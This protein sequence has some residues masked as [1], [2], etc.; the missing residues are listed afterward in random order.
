MQFSRPSLH[1]PVI[2]APEHLALAR[3]QMAS[4]PRPPA[5]AAAAAADTLT[6]PLTTVSLNSNFDA[7]VDVWFPG[8]DPS[9]I[10]QLVVDSGNSVL[11]MPRWE[12]ITAVPNH[13]SSYTVLA[14]GHEPWGCPANIVRGP[15]CIPTTTG[16]P[17]VI[18]CVFFA[19][20]GDG[21]EGGRTAN[22]GTGCI[23]PWSANGWA[24]P[25]GAALTL[26]A[27][28]SYNA[29]YP[30]AVFDYAPAAT[31]QGAAGVVKVS[32]G[33]SLILGK[34]QPAGFTAFDIL[35][36]LEWM[37]VRPL[38]LAIGD[39]NTPWPGDIDSPIAVIDTGGGPVFLSDPHG[40][41]YRGAW[42]D[43]VDNPAWAS[44]SDSCE[45]VGAKI[46]VTIGTAAAKFSYIID[47][48]QFPR[49]AQGLTLVMCKK[50][51]YMMDQQGMNIGGISAL[52]NRILVDYGG[53]RVGLQTK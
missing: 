13:A 27:P 51:H 31:I 25:N 44:S 32:A 3:A 42:S 15:V 9:K 37:S 19:C 43:P 21:P 41:V 38:A 53:C 7:Y 28:L 5:A 30:F 36:N 29:A 24:S 20:T 12:D 6:V 26:Q 49:S 10:A 33:S 46:A 35:P 34:T 17:C 45:S 50:N 39:S 48:T 1:P 16:N 22:F 11:I 23:S 47:P 14:A 52:V 8:G 2:Q 18:N 40:Y 4:I